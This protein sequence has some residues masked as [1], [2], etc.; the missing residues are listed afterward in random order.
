M[1]DN[2]KHRSSSRTDEFQLRC[3]EGS[4][5]WWLSVNS[6]LNGTTSKENDKREHEIIIMYLIHEV[7]DK[8]RSATV[9]TPFSHSS[10]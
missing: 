5:R 10:S 1:V 4:D 9:E 6:L 8:Q 7:I 3:K 2:E